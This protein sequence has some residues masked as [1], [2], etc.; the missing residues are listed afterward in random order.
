MGKSEVSDC[1][2]KQREIPRRAAPKEREGRKMAGHSPWMEKL[3]NKML[4]SLPASGKCQLRILWTHSLNSGQRIDVILKMQLDKN[5]YL[6]TAS[7]PS[8]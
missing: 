2:K 8:L 4:V 3:K 5:P 7:K 6:S 1:C